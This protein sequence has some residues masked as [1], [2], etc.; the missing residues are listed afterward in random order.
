MT[1]S[2]NRGD[3]KAVT[4]GADYLIGTEQ[5]NQVT[6]RGQQHPILLLLFPGEVDPLVLGLIQHQEVKVGL[7]VLTL[8]RIPVDDLLRR[9]GCNVGKGR[10]AF[11]RADVDQETEA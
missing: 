10:R 4:G 8:A 2:A 6:V 9:I 1:I 5:G 3:P 11:A 7:V